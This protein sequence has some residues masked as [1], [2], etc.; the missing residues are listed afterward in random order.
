[1]DSFV[2]LMYT[3]KISDGGE[4]VASN[5]P[6]VSDPEHEVLEAVARLATSNPFSPDRIAAKRLKE[7]QERWGGYDFEYLRFVRE[8]KEGDEEDASTGHWRPAAGT[9][10]GW[11]KTAKAKAKGWLVFLIN[12]LA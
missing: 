12:S 4:P 1:M 5:A 2:R 8:E 6:F 3:A 7:A 9:F 11:P 10:E